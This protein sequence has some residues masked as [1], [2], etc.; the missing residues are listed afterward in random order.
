M[1]WLIN[2][3]YQPQPIRWLLWPLSLLYRLAIWL[4]RSLYRWGL[5]KQHHL[6]IPVIIIGNITVGGTGKTPFTIWLA[7]QLQQAG[8]RPGIIS[9][10]YGGKADHYPQT[11]S[12]QSDPEI[13]GDEPIIISRQT[14]CPMVVAPDRVA[15]AQLL[16]Q[17]SDC[18]IIIADDGLQHYAL[19][20]DIEIVI[21]DGVR[22]FGNQFC[23]PAGPLREPL[24]RLNHVDFIVHNGGENSAEFMMFL[25]HQ[26]VCNLANPALKKELDEFINQPLHAVAGIGNPDHFFEKLIAKGLTFTPHPFSDHHAFQKKDLDFNDDTTIL[27]TEKDAV[28]CHHFAKNNMWYIPITASINGK[29]DQLILKKL[30]NITHG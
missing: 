20:R 6:P 27:M 10:G 18:N 28:K 13:V 14:Q 29:L 15:A 25:T 22:Q 12:P 7:K 30:R 17:Q 19:G 4:R 2:S 1:N 24:S 21:V 11:V 23:L 9:R 3:W 5:F 16:L 26:Q 8:Y